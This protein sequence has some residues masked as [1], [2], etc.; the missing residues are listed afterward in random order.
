VASTPPAVAVVVPR[1]SSFGDVAGGI[2]QGG[3]W[4]TLSPLPPPPVLGG[5]HRCIEDALKMHCQC[6]VWEG[7][8]WKDKTPKAGWMHLSLNRAGGQMDDC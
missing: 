1:T 2:V 5:S 6:R 8:L 7:L 4:F 3:M